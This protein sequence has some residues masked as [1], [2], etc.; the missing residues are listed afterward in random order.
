[1]LDIC[2]DQEELGD[3]GPRQDMRNAFS[4]NRGSKL[5]RS[6]GHIWIRMMERD[7][8]DW[9]STDGDLLLLATRS[10]QASIST[11]G[12]WYR[13][14][15]STKRHPMY[16][17]RFSIS[18]PMPSVIFA[19]VLGPSSALRGNEF[20]MQKGSFATR[21]TENPIYRRKFAAI[22]KRRRPTACAI[23]SAASEPIFRSGTG[24]CEKWESEQCAGWIAQ[25]RGSP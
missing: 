12:E 19:A 23:L 9:S 3:E 16:R 6:C 10:R 8:Q 7:G 18:A 5:C 14:Q 11:R 22:H 4:S 17:H 1:M 20:P 2:D 25:V 24:R 13:R 15:R 21:Q